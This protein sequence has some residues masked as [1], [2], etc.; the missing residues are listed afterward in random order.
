MTATVTDE[1]MRTFEMRRNGEAHRQEVLAA[2]EDLLD[3]ARG[4]D[5]DA[6]A[7][8]AL[9]MAAA[10]FG[11]RAAR[12]GGAALLELRPRRGE[13]PHGGFRQG[14]VGTRGGPPPEEAARAGGVPDLRAL[15][16]LP[17]RVPAL[18]AGAG[19]RRAVPGVRRVAAV[20]SKDRR[21]LV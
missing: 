6:F 17:G 11:R 18:L 8:A 5:G 13:P 9:E 19:K 10:M 3:T 4:H 16:A 20:E 14:L 15:R 1:L 12:Q 21:A 2:R 7:E